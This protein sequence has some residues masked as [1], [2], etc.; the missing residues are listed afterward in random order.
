L[1][2]KFKIETLLAALGLSQIY[3]LISIITTA[4]VTDI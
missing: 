1:Y 3:F 4:I 2:C